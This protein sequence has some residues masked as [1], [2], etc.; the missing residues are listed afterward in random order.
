MVAARSR[1][2][3]WS[4]PDLRHSRIFRYAGNNIAIRWSLLCI[5]GSRISDDFGFQGHPAKIRKE[6]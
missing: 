3:A 2:D 1:F 5:S 6:E 4:G